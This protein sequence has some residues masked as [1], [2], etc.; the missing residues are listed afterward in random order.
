MTPHRDE[1][2]SRSQTP[3]AMPRLGITPRSELPESLHQVNLDAAGIDV[4]AESH[5]VAVP[6]DR[7]TE[8]VREFAAFTCDLHRLAD[9]LEHCGIQTVAMESTGVYW[10][11]LMELLEE[12]GFEVE[13]VDPR[14]LKQV[15]G[16]KTDVLD[17][18]WIQQLHTFGLLASAFRPVD[19]VCVLRTYMRQR[20]MLIKDAARHIQH[21]QKALTQMNIK[22]QHVVSDITGATGMGIL[23]AILDGERDPQKLASLRDYRCKHSVETIAKALEGHWREEHLFELRQ[24]IAL[25]D[26]YQQQ[27]AQC[28][29][30]LEPCLQRFEDRT[31]G[32]QVPK[33]KGKRNK[34]HAPAFDIR[35]YLYQMTGVDLTDIDGIEAY[36]A[37]QL[38]SEIGL[39]MSRWS[40]V[41]HFSSWLG[42]CPGN[43]ISGGKRLS[44]RSKQ[45]ACRAAAILRLCASSLARSQSAL[46]AFY[47]RKRAQL[48]APK[49]IT[50]TA[51]KL[52]RIIYSMLRDGTEYVDPG[53]EYYEERYRQRAL[54]NLHRSAKRFGFKL[55]AV[56]EAAVEATA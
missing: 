33:K 45:N 38:I 36:S 17:C 47:R 52:A 24:A 21:M 30:R 8:P 19:E 40:T 2:L 44:G 55:V 1:D 15:P 39:D 35:Q 20:S 43:K 49:A 27:I 11:P 10:I 3:G 12:R 41:K 48:G 50:A 53:V 32:Q 31:D 26:F 28:D 4:G 5:F 9:W 16:R 13:L 25:Y 54:S 23:R 51:H 6:K 22:L 56:D 34:G 46:G 14:R 18:Q 7:D 42:V 29:E 37:L